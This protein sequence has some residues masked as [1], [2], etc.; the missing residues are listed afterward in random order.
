MIVDVVW[1]RVVRY[2]IH[3]IVVV[4]AI[5]ICHMPI[6]DGR[7]SLRSSL[8]LEVELLRCGLLLGPMH[9]TTLTGTHTE[10]LGSARVE[11]LVVLRG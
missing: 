1:T 10:G 8:V 4:N 6:D 3:M 11:L 9:L 5:V 2:M 7:R